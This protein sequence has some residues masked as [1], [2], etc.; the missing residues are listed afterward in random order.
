[1]T[2]NGTGVWRYMSMNKSFMSYLRALLSHLTALR[3]LLSMENLLQKS[4]EKTQAWYRQLEKI[5]TDLLLEQENPLT[6]RLEIEK[7][8]IKLR[9]HLRNEK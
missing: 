9:K 5:A 2:T 8:F 6:A 3:R 4:P 7:H 1:M